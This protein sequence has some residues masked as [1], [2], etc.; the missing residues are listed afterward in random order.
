MTLHTPDAIILGAGPVGLF[1]V[2]ELGLLNIHAHVV[3]ALDQPGG[4]CQELYPAK[5]IYDIPGLPE[6]TGRQLTENLLKQIAP[7]KPTLHLGQTVTRL[8]H[9]HDTGVGTGTDPRTERHYYRVTTD[10]GTE[11][12][13][14][15]LIIAAGNGAFTPRRLTTPGADEAE[16]A[17]RLHYAVRDAAHFEGQRLLILGGGDSAFDWANF[18]ASKARQVTLGN[19]STFYRAA[20]AS[21][22]KFTYLTQTNDHLSIRIGPAGTPQSIALAPDGVTV[23]FA[24]GTTHTYDHILCFYGLIAKIGALAEFNLDM[25]G[26]AFKVD[27]C[28]YETNRPGVFAVGDCNTYPNKRKLILSGFHEAALA[29]HAAHDYVHPGQPL[30]FQ[31]TTTSNIMHQ[32]LGV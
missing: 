10:A 29:A 11:L 17:R 1:T 28:R 24:D 20:P 14:P 16:Q 31:Y 15:V 18:Y 25:K 3:D 8:Q 21:S 2:F 22:S 7:F 27:T 30:L 13:A 12:L 26:A 9:I 32:R 4:Q 23:T 19:R 5:P 6:V